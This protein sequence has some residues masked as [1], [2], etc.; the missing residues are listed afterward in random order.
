MSESTIVEPTTTGL[1]KAEWFKIANHRTPVVTGVVMLLAVLAPAAVLI[2]YT[3]SNIAAYGEA[4]TATYS[5]AAPLTAIVFG[6]WLLGTEY[7]Q[8]TTKRLLT[9]EPR[10]LRALGTKAAVGGV[11]LAGALVVTA[12]AGWGASW[13]VGSLNDVTV[14]WN[15]RDPIRPR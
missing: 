8:G 9:S 1:A 3:P 4:F 12:L 6:G 7:R 10:R 15:G 11:T 13:L 5:L 14:A 2:F